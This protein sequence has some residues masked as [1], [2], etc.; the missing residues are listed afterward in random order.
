MVSAWP[1]VGDT[2]VDAKTVTHLIEGCQSADVLVICRNGF[3]PSLPIDAIAD[4]VHPLTGIVRE[5]NLRFICI[6]QMGNPTAGLCINFRDALKRLYT[7]TA[8]MPFFLHT[9]LHR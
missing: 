3:I 8:F 6:E 7:K 4:N 2:D 9:F 5:R 1:Q